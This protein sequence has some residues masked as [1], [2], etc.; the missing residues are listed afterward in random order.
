[1]RPFAATPR[2]RANAQVASHGGTQGL[3]LALWCVAA[4]TAVSTAASL[5]KEFAD[6]ELGAYGWRVGSVVLAVA[7]LACARFSLSAAR[8]LLGVFAPWMTAMTALAA[9]RL[10]Q[11]TVWLEWLRHAYMIAVGACVFAGC[12]TPVGRLLL[13]RTVLLLLACILLL[14]IQPVVMMLAGGWSWEQAR[15]LKADDPGGLRVNAV[16]FLFA[17]LVAALWTQPGRPRVRLFVTAAFLGASVLFAVRS[18]PIS[19]VLAAALV[20]GYAVWR[21]HRRV[22]AATASLIAGAILLLPLGF[23]LLVLSAPDSALAATLAGRAQLWR[24]SLAVWEQ[25]P[26]IGAGPDAL[27]LGVH[28]DLNVGTFFADWQRE[29]LFNLMKGGFHNIW[30]DTLASKGLVGLAGLFASYFLLL[31]AGLASAAAGSRALLLITLLLFSRGY[32]E[33]S[34]LFS[35]ENSPHD[36]VAF[37]LVAASLAAALGGPTEAPATQVPQPARRPRRHGLQVGRHVR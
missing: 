6:I 15:V 7:M 20:A 36:F 30:L 29:S 12:R 21:G 9:I 23:I 13:T 16:M 37:V 19:A 3:D 33:V 31:R 22:S 26:L 1:L 27:I 4:I 14:C 8:P 2:P 25:A 34:G 28:R 24:I 11:P 35:Y 5:P 17:L 18:A 10:D 32:V